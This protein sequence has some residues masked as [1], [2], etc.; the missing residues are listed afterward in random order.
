[1]QEENIQRVVQL[2][3][4]TAGYLVQTNLLAYLLQLEASPFSQLCS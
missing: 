2:Y 1:M 3:A 4:D